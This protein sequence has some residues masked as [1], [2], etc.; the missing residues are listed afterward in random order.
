MA[1]AIENGRGSVTYESLSAALKKSVQA[2]RKPV[3]DLAQKFGVVRES[4]KETAPKVMRLF[5]AIKAD[6]ES[7]TFVDFA[8]M[9]DP[10]IPTHAADREAVQGYRNHKVYYTLDYMRRMANLRPRGRQGVRD[11]ATDALARAIATI[12]QVVR[13][14]APVWGAVQA[15]FQFNERV[16]GRLRKRVEA[17]KPLF[18]VNL[19]PRAVVK[20]GNVIHMERQTATT[21]QGEATPATPARRVR[22]QVSQPVAAAS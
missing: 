9:F 14:P 6:H 7:V 5:N 2:L 10:S 19:P 3:T 11:S 4:L 22:R 16:M 12:L 1:E 8:R 18:S 13:D 20:V 17:T 15:E 21:E